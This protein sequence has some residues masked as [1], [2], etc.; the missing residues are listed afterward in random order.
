MADDKESIGERVRARRKALDKSQDWLAEMAG[1][2]QTTIDKIEH[3]RSLR[4]RFLPAVFTALGL[5]LDELVTGM[6]PLNIEGLDGHDG[7]DQ[8][9]PVPVGTKKDL[10]VYSSAEGGPGGIIFS[11]EPIDYLIRPEPLANV[12]AG[13]AMYT[14]GESMSPA[15]EQGDLLLINPHLPYRSGDDVLIYRI[16]HGQNEAVVKRL[17]R[18]TAENWQLEQFNPAKNLSLPRGLWPVCH[19]I[20]G[21]Y[22]RR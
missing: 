6:A 10:P 9:L 20:V 16:E 3:N 11:P 15:F 13:Y 21:K 8:A 18:A 7:R 22:S 2:S 1:T 17:R 4:S 12:K 14:M 5:P 19:V